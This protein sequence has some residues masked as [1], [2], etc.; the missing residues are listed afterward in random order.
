MQ[1]N[2]SNHPPKNIKFC[3]FHGE[4]IEKN[5]TFEKWFVNSLSEGFSL[6]SL[7]TVD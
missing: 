3:V 2:F 7:F 4:V 1:R 5:R 6:K